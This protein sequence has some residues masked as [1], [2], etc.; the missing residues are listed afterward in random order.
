ML[1]EGLK[2]I[3]S[4]L[5]LL[6]GLQGTYFYYNLGNL[7]KSK[8]RSRFKKEKEFYKELIYPN[9]LCFDIGAN[10]GS[11]TYIFN[12]IRAKVVAFEPDQR[13][14]K[15]LVKRYKNKKNIKLKNM[16]VGDAKG[17]SNISIFSSHTLTTMDKNTVDNQLKDIRLNETFIV[18]NELVET[19]TLDNLILEYGKPD[20]CK[21]AVVGYELNVL[22]G[23]G[24]PIKTISLAMTSPYHNDKLLL[25][26]EH[27]AKIGAY[28]FNIIHHSSIGFELKN[29]VTANEIKQI[30]TE[31][32][33]NADPRY[34]EIFAKL[35]SK[36]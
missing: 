36:T 31:L 32:K 29:W 6:E 19:D 26:I 22:K 17:Q 10:I 13:A 8:N 7:V 3:L 9:S 21:I 33:I 30:I 15:I 27:L 2:K 1:V 14:F 34:N 16:S 35:I 24:T 18:K 5:N 12:K 25:C 11:K 4:K 20:F 23:L 28:E